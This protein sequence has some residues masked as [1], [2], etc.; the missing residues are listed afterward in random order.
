VGH[1]TMERTTD[2]EAELQAFKTEIEGSKWQASLFGSGS[3]FVCLRIER[4][5]PTGEIV[6]PQAL[7][8]CRRSFAEAA[9]SAR[10]H[11]F[12]KP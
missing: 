9:K 1:G 4:P 12:P 11:I 3:A 6:E 10:K 8:I 5:S 2:V 7:E